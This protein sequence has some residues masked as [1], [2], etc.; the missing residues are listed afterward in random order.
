MSR[1]DI[2]DLY[3]RYGDMVYG[4]CRTLLGDP[5]DAAEATQDIFLKLHRYR[6]GFRGEASPTTYLF[7]VT[8]TTCL[9]HLR[10]KR[11]RREEPV[12]ELPA[13]THAGDS[14]LDRVALRDLVAVLLAEEDERTTAAAVYCF[15]DGMTYAEAG[16]L[17]GV[18]GGAVRKRLG[19]FRQRARARLSWLEDVG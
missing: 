3:R 15:V 5:G 11:R 14:L 7:K 1:L 18:S 19:K 2:A 17:L 6:A 8:T 13:A 10:S 16:E 4:R 12:A 9:N